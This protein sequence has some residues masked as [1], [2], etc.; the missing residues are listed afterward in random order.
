ME[1]CVDTEVKLENGRIR[2]AW[3]RTVRRNMLKVIYVDKR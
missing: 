1:V 2:E 3:E